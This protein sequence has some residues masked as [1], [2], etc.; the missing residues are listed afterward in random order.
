MAIDSQTETKIVALIARGDSYKSIK[1]QLNKDGVSLSLPSISKIKERNT[2]ALSYI[3]GEIVAHELSKTT[4]ILDKARDLIDQKLDGDQPIALKDLTTLSKEM[5]NQSQIESGKP[6]SI[7][8]SPELAKA[9]LKTLLEAINSGK[10][11]DIAKAIFI[12]A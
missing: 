2:Q 11:E 12:D 7:T 4:K 3:K 1:E 5:F 10:D 6:T 8:N 9:Q